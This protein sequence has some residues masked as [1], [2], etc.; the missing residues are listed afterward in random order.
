MFV[1]YFV[2]AQIITLLLALFLALIVKNYTVCALNSSLLD[3]NYSL[4][5]KMFAGSFLQTGSATT[6]FHS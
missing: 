5:L 1:G 2:F 6:F 4:F 3:V